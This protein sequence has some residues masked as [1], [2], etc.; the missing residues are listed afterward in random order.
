MTTHDDLCF[1]RFNP[2]RHPVNKKFDQSTI[3]A[4]QENAP[5]KRLKVQHI[6]PAPVPICIDPTLIMAPAQMWCPWVLCAWPLQGTTPIYT[7][8]ESQ[9]PATGE[10]VDV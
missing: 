5:R 8:H 10:A 2:I 1:S 7:C 4:P 3:D 9:T 6:Q